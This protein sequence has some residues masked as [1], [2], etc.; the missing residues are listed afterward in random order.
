ME[1]HT[2]TLDLPRSLY[3][4]V[5]RVAEVT[6]QSPQAVV[7]SMLA[8]ALPPLDDVDPEEAAELAAL[9]L[10]EDAGLWKIAREQLLLTDQEA[11]QDLLERQSQG[12]LSS[13]Q[14][15]ELQQLLDQYGKTMVGKAHASL[16]LARRG[17][18]ITLP[19]PL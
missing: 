8:H 7:R 16:L 6:G 12:Q 9:A 19:E 5:Y 2:L 10:L 14:K 4:S 15:A 11:L 1:T 17:Y 13:T 3:D 18:Q